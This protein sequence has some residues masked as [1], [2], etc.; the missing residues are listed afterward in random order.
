M[1]VT[2]CRTLSARISQVK[3]G[4]P[5][6]REELLKLTNNEVD[7]VNTNGELKSTFDVFYELGS[8]WKDLSSM[9]KSQI[10]NDVFGKDNLTT[11]Y[12][13]LENYEKLA[14][15]RETLTNSSGSVEGEFDRYLDSTSAKLEQFKTSVLQIWTGL[16]NSDMT[17]G[18]VSGLT[19]VTDS[20][21]F[22]INKFG[23]FPT[24]I[25]TVIGS[26]TALN[27]SFRD[28]AKTVL[29]CIN[30]INKMFSSLEQSAQKHQA[31]IKVYQ[32]K[33]KVTEGMIKGY[34][35][36]GLNTTAL[37]KRLVEEKASLNGAKVATMGLKV[38]TVALES[39]MTMGLSLVISEVVSKISEFLDFSGKLDNALESL[40]DASDTFGEM[41]SADALVD[42]WSKLDYAINNN[43]LSAEEMKSKKSELTEVQRQLAE[44]VEGTF[45]A[46]DTE[47]N[48]IATNIELVQQQIEA[49]RQLA[50]IKAKNAY[51]ETIEDLGMDV[52]LGI[53]QDFDYTFD[54][55]GKKFKTLFGD[56]SFLDEYKRIKSELDKTGGIADKDDVETFEKINEAM[57]KTN[58]HIINLKNLGADVSSSKI[59]NFDTGEFINASDY[60]NNLKDGMD[61]TGN[62]A[63]GLDGDLSILSGGMD[64]LENSTDDATSAINELGDAFSKLN[65]PIKILQQIK[66]EMAEF[67]YITDDTYNDILTSGNADLI[68]LLGDADNFMS[69]VDKTL[70]DYQ[71]RREDVANQL[72]N[73]AYNEVNGLGETS[74]VIQDNMGQIGVI[75]DETKNKIDELNRAISG[76][77]SEAMGQDVINF[78]EGVQKKVLANAELMRL[79]QDSFAEY[80]N[81]N[82]M[83]YGVDAENFVN[84]LN[85]KNGNNAKW[86][87][88]VIRQVAQTIN[89]N[90]KNYSVDTQNWAKALN[91]KNLNNS[92]M[93]TSVNTAMAQ[94]LNAMLGQY[95]KDYNNFKTTTNAK[96]DMYNKF[97]QGVNAGIS[98]ANLPTFNKNGMVVD[99]NTG[100]WRF[101]NANELNEINKTKTG[102]YPVIGTIS[103]VGGGLNL[104]PVSGTHVGS[105]GTHVGSGGSGGTGGKSGS[106]S[107]E[108]DYTVENLNLEDY[109]QRH[110]KLE[111]KIR[112]VQHAQD[113][114]SQKI[115]NTYGKKKLDLQYE[116]IKNLEK[117]KSL[118]KQLIDSKWNE[119]WDKRVKLSGFGI[120][121]DENW[122]IKNMT[123]VYTK[124]INASNAINDSTEEGSNREKEAQKNI[125]NLESTI[126]D[127]QS[128]HGEIQGLEK[129][130]ESLA[131]TIKNVYK[132]ISDSYSDLESDLSSIIKDKVGELI[133]SQTEALDKL[134]DKINKQWEDD[135]W[136]DTKAQ[137][138][139]DILDL[140]SQLEDAMKVGNDT[141]IKNL[142]KELEDVQ[143]EYS[144]LIK[145]NEKENILNK[146]EEENENL[147]NKKE[148]M[149]SAENLSKMIQEA[150]ENG[151]VNIGGKVYET[152]TLMEEYTKSSVEGYQSQK[153]ALDEYIRSLE[154]CMSYVT[155]LSGINSQLGFTNSV[156][157]TTEMS[158]EIAKAL[159]SNNSNVSKTIQFNSP[160]I[161]VDNLSNDIDINKLSEEFYNKVLKAFNGA[162]PSSI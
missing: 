148:E 90:G 36:L 7:L 146:I 142:K 15:V 33:I 105:G 55:L 162:L 72:I 111:D 103:N 28:N 51:Q 104:T 151:W 71:K 58:E 87:N 114:L 84:S 124:L 74:N 25:T 77:S 98:T 135:E 12:A 133:E 123:E 5:K 49:Q 13:I 152:Q 158:R 10:G 129:D 141:Q 57:T 38:A 125:K 73:T 4:V 46:Y 161:N 156:S 150:I 88:D 27:K 41:K 134:K 67:G 136:E 119:L 83:N 1:K 122:N 17:K 145:E 99:K 79:L 42:K 30:P 31:D 48:K 18:V 96:I 39:A 24:V 60:F 76:N 2:E 112:D 130:Y 95:Q 153:I 29:S 126:K 37:N 75:S 101:P 32:D 66:E 132:D 94:A 61:N 138:E 44:T 137:K 21:G 139:Q 8:V 115:E 56:Y 9:Q 143:K 110:Y 154:T 131:D 100:M 127:Y 11:A 47:G 52:N 85:T 159:E 160:L 149:L 43:N 23:A 62:S 93:C 147:E 6:F 59:F 128:L 82:A 63:N 40:K 157:Y 89:A 144:D 116:Y 108:K 20:I 106:G 54:G 121:F 91:N 35:E 86:V 102:A 16:I 69:N 65:S 50:E 118:T 70:A 53:L 22:V 117:E 34:K 45:T 92:E 113:I 140:K 120:D 14:E 109:I 155:Q 19:A 3:N 80:I 97:A 68:A 64:D 26:M 78:Q 107:S 81:T